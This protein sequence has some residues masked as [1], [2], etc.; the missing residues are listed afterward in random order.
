VDRLSA[1]P[2]GR[3]LLI[4]LQNHVICEAR[5][6]AGLKRA[7]RTIV[8]IVLHHSH[9]HLPVISPSGYFIRVFKGDI[10]EVIF[11]M[12]LLVFILLQSGLYIRV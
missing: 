1:Q 7:D 12:G 6:E 2:T 11:H 4:L 3:F 10:L 5:E 9:E 8:R